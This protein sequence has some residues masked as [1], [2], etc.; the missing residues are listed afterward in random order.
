MYGLLDS[1]SRE[2]KE[3]KE[4]NGKNGNGGRVLGAGNNGEGHGHQ[5]VAPRL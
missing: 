4:R 2:L 5:S 3:A 1:L